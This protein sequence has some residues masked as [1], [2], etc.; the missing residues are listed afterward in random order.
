[1]TIEVIFEPQ[2]SHVIQHFVADG[3]F[4]EPYV[5]DPCTSMGVLFDGRLAAGF[6]WHDEH[7]DYNLIELSAYSTTR[8][9]MNRWSLYQVFNLPFNVFRHRAVIAKHSEKNKRVRRIWKSLGA[10]E[11][12]VPLIRGDD[13]AE[14]VAVLHR[15]VWLKSKFGPAAMEERYG[16]EE[17]TK[18]A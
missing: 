16:Q 4:G 5:F 18:A 10:E 3:L 6:V 15:D 7:V 2:G 14:C 1:M 9:W 8:R 11:T 17:H 13:E 12:I